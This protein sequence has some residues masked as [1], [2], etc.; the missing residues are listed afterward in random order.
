LDWAR[1]RGE[2]GAVALLEA[3]ARKHQNTTKCTCTCM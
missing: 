3:Y 2:Q 1:E